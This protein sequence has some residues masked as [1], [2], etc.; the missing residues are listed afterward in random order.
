M[1]KG[2]EARYGCSG[3]RGPDAITRGA[4]QSGVWKEKTEMG[5]EW[6]RRGRS[7]GD[8]EAPGPPERRKKQRNE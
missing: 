4:A 6:S 7:A 1:D 2:T 3:K 5:A 8:G